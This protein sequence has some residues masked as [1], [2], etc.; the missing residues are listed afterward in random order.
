MGLHYDQLNTSIENGAVL[1]FVIFCIENI[2]IRLGVS[3]ET[4][5]AALT[6]KSNILK[7]YIVPCYDILHTQDKEYITDDILSVMEKEGVEV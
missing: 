3:G 5:Y 1:E 2:A 7:Q 6:Q 4:V